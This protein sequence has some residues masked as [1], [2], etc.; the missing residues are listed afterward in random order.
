V[1]GPSQRS[2]P[3]NKQHSQETDIHDSGGIRTHNPSKRKAADPRHRPRGHWKLWIINKTV[4]YT[5]K[6]VD[7]RRLGLCVVSNARQLTF[8]AAHYP[9]GLGTSSDRCENFTSHAVISTNEGMQLLYDVESKSFE[10]RQPDSQTATFL[11]LPPVMQGPIKPPVES[12]NANYLPTNVFPC[13]SPRS[14][15][16]LTDACHEIIV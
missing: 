13:S 14:R 15:R 5:I 1:I 2:L 10:L 3:D 11:I 8:H 7:C 4:M 12:T 9:R 6:Y 16:S